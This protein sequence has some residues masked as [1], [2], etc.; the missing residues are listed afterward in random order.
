[1]VA[2]D[3]RVP[4]ECDQ[5]AVPVT[6]PAEEGALSHAGLSRDR[7]HGHA[8]RAV[9]TDQAAGG[10]PQPGAVAGG[11]GSFGVGGDAA[12]CFHQ[13]SPATRMYTLPS[14]MRTG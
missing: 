2:A 8:F 12:R 11:I 5:E 14:S 7:F 1:M 6:E 4:E 13:P 3:S 10:L 9:L